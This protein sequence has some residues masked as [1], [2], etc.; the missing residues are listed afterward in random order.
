ME[1]LARLEILKKLFQV[2]ARA[3]IEPV[4]AK[5]LHFGGWRRTESTSTPPVF[6]RG[7]PND[8][9]CVS[10][11]RMMIV[12]PDADQDQLRKFSPDFQ[13]L[14]LPAITWNRDHTRGFVRWNSGWAGGTY[15]LVRD[16]AGWKI[17]SISEWV[18]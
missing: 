8:Y 3:L 18:S 16:G 7:D 12:Y 10:I 1:T 4:G 9:R 15:R 11:D 6:L 2:Q 13:L 5:G 17:E 14:E